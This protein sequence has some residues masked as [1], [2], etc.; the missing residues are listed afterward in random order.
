MKGHAMLTLPDAIISVLKPFS[1]LFQ[2]RTW[3][4][5]QVLLVGA[6][7]SPGKRTVTSALRVMGLSDDRSFARYHHVLNRA[8]WSPLQLGRVLLWLLIRHLDQG[9]SPLVFGIDET[10][11]RRRGKKI[12]AKGIYRDGVRSS[13][14]HFVKAS[15][16]RWIS[17]MWLTTIPWACR[18]WA[19]PVLTALAPSERYYQ[20]MGRSPKKLTDW[21]RQI[22]LQLRRWLPNRA[23]VLVADSSYAVLDLLHFCQSLTQPVTLITRLRLDAALYEPAPP[24]EPGQNGRPRVKGQRRP[25]LKVLLDLPETDWSKAFV[26]WYDGTTRTV[27]LTSQTAVW[28]HCGKPPVRIRWVLIRDPL[29]QFRPQA[30]L[31]TDLAVAPVQII[32]WFVLRWQLEVTFQE[33]RAH[34]GV[35]TQRQWS[36]GAIARTTPVLF[37]LFSWISLAAHMLQKERPATPRSAAWYAKSLPTFADAIAQVRRDLWRAS[38]TFSMSPDKPDITEIPAPLFN[39][40]I[41]SLAYAA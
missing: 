7:L 5:T 16:L 22:I 18:T 36:D 27:E 33:V 25:T 9:D 14:S 26:A 40:L 4:K 3:M 1:M 39:R 2:H 12:K 13:G 21:A 23:L 24:R 37:G 8:V 38:E 35:E 41:E 29:G 30:L 11:E 19:L 15:G 32:E 17:L 28:Y 10:L 20:K 31:S 34:L 6:I